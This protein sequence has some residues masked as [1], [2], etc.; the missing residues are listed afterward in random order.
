MIRVHNSEQQMA[1]PTNNNTNNTH[2]NKV[3]GSINQNDRFLEYVKYFI[4]T[5]FLFFVLIDMIQRHRI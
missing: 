5:Y 3:P 2:K 1:S 4:I